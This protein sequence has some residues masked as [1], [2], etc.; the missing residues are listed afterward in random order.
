MG[1]RFYFR[2]QKLQKHI[3]DYQK[4]FS[5][6]IKAKDL[7]FENLEAFIEDLKT[8]EKLLIVTNKISNYISN[9]LNAN[10]VS[11]EIKKSS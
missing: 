5:R 9:N 11:E 10:L 6:R 8:L 4:L 3:D 2:W 1:F 7:K